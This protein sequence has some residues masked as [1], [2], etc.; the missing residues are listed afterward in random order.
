MF[1]FCVKFICRIM[2]EPATIQFPI[3]NEPESKAELETKTHK[4]P[5]KY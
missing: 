3:T 5:R 1:I 4:N 2:G